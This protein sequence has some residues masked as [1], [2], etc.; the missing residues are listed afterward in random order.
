MSQVLKF[1]T[2]KLSN[3]PF[4]KN[5]SVISFD[6]LEPA[7]L[8]Q[9]LSDVIGE[10]DSKHKID[11]REEPPDQMVLR[12]FEALRIFRYKLPSDSEKLN[13]FRQG[14]VTGDKAIVYPL[15][16][17]LLTKMPEL[18]KRAY[19]ARYLVKIS[20]P[21]DFMQD[22]EI[23]GLYQQ[24]E[25]AVRNFK[26]SHKMF[27]RV[28]SS[29]LTTAEVKKDIS[30]MQEEKDQ[31]LRRV[32]RI[33]KKLE[34][35]PTS[36]TM[37][38][39]AKRLR[40]EREKEVKLSKQIRE[41]KLSISNLDQR[42]QRTQQQVKELR[43]ATTGSTTT[44]LL[45]R[46]EEET[47]VNQ[48]M[49]SEKL[50]KEL[51]TTKKYVEDLNKVISQPAMNQSFLDQLTQQLR[52]VNSALNKLIEKRMIANEPFDD[53]I[54]L[55]RQQAAIVTRKKST[56]AEML[57][58]TR[59]KLSEL[60]DRLE[61][62]K[63]Q[64]GVSTVEN[65]GE[66]V[67][68]NVMSCLKSD[69]FQRYVAKLRSKNTIYKQKRAELSELRAEKGILSRTVE[70]LR[71]EEND[72]KTLLANT[73]STQIT[74]DYLEN[75]ANLSKISKQMS[76]LNEQKCTTPE[77]LSKVIQQLNGRITAKRE[78]LAPV[79][80]ELRQLRQKAQ[81]L[82]QIHAEKKS[83]YDALT[84]GQETQSIRLE[85]EVRT[86]RE[87]EKNEESKFHY[88]T[89]SLEILHIQ[90]NRLQE[91][92]R[93]YV[94]SGTGHSGLSSNRDEK[95]NESAIEKRKSYRD[96]YTRKIAEQE[97]LT[98]T[99][100]QEQKHLLENEKADLKQ[101]NLWTDLLHLLEIKQI[102][103]EANEAREKAGGEYAD[104][105]KIEKDR[106]LL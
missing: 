76:M 96:I 2:Q 63:N 1:I 4:N 25:N 85:Q 40:L 21:V 27:E 60:D 73:D 56:A 46:I 87:A 94:S 14:L 47:R 100:K 83:A 65:N 75:Q 86:I 71:N 78:Q 38:E 95:M 50:P 24:Y 12:L 98:R 77:E 67:N 51:S 22:E 104:V 53:K 18:R 82:G 37:L 31:L 30:T 49:L 70:V 84:A 61:K 13:L 68:R 11:I 7:N 55:F 92:M 32:E 8:L 23:S 90:Q 41:Q 91:E 93:G 72:V 48:Y 58:A 35:F 42:I 16:E 20:I 15:L 69:E 102:A 6:A 52:D 19:L 99:L 36:G 43:K 29:G 57:T 59:N 17:W 62:M 64:L 34:T 74:G 88:L 97:A 81:E 10:V 9:V 28:K 26:E 45:Q 3:E 79:I 5:Y 66:D 106:M 105:V 33:K 89:A 44:G 54:S 103:R 80:R 39:M 101:V